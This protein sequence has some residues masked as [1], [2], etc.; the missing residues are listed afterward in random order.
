MR[1]WLA[2]IG[3]GLFCGGLL[4]DELFLVGDARLTG[5]IRAIDPMGVVEL[6]SALSPE[7]LLLNPGSVTKV[8]FS[9][10]APAS[11]SS[12]ALVELT[13]GDVV[14]GV[15]G[16]L[17]EAALELI[18]PHA[19]RLLIPRNFLE[20]VQLGVRQSEPIYSGPKS[21]EEWSSG[22]DGQKGWEFA[23]N[24]LAANGP[25]T[26][27]QAFDETPP[28]FILKFSLK[29]QT[30]P[31]FQIYFADPLTPAAGRIDR[32]Y[33]QFNS[34]GLEVKRESSK[35]KRF[36]TVII[37]ARTPENFASNEVD[38]EIRV[39]R[40]SSRIHLLL[41]GEPEGAGIDPAG[42]PP[43]AGGLSFINSS[44]V[45]ANQEVSKIQVLEFD[46][47]SARHLSEDRGDPMF[48]SLIS[49]DDDRWGGHL[50]AIRKGPE[51]P[52][53][54]FKSDF[55]EEPLELA[56]SDVSTIFFAKADDGK[57][58]PQQEHP[59]VLRL[60]GGGSLRVASC[61]FSDGDIQ[62][63][64]PLLGPLKINRA[65]VSSLEKVKPSPRAAPPES[66]EAK[67]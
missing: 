59:F 26:A 29:W 49:R 24:A 44:P 48:D 62:A 3:T 4:A 5:T 42:E 66:N 40:T 12:A 46:N 1:L 10:S 64:H 20:S 22:G 53:F 50:Q 55:Q 45:G 58:L 32:Y 37:L 13:N 23:E 31:S 21:G 38:V 7:P 2:I 54:L 39:D 35:G 11:K 9:G 65:G 56:E 36:Q 33:M 60:T 17:D 15:I 18:T 67:E 6:A 63:E 43:A 28:Q 19:G 61:V 57:T 25:A 14:A 41:N 34:A 51:G 8:E 16:G 47:S 27:S 30:N 52:V